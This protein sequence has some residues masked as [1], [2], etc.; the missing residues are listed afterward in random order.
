VAINAV[1]TSRL[2]GD[3]ADVVKGTNSFFIF[4][5]RFVIMIVLRLDYLL[6][7]NTEVPGWK[8][9]VMGKNHEI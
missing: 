4:G 7:S 9:C 2:T 6:Y 1:M 5:F 8:P 3:Q